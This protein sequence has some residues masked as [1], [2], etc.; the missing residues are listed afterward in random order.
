M[1]IDS[2]SVRRIV[3]LLTVTALG[4]AGGAVPAATPALAASATLQSE[5]SVRP[6][7]VSSSAYP[8]YP[9]S[10]NLDY[11]VGVTGTFQFLSYRTDTV[12]FAWRLGDDGPF[13]TAPAADRQGSASITPD[14]AGMQTLYVRDVTADGSRL[15][16][17][18]YAFNVDDGPRLVDPGEYGTELVVGESRT[19]RLKPGARDVVSYTYRLRDWRGTT[20]GTGT[21]AARP[22]GTADL[23]WTATH[24]EIDNLTVQS[25][26]ADGTVSATRY[27]SYSVDGATPTVSRIP[28]VGWVEP[29]SFTARTRMADPVEYVVTV[30]S[31][32]ASRQTLTPAADGSATFQLLPTVKGT[33]YIYVFARDAA[34]VQTDTAVIL[35]SVSNRPPV[36]STAFPANGIGRVWPGSFTFTAGMPGTTEFRYRLNGGP[37]T[38]LPAGPDGKATLAWT[39]PAV[40]GY[41]LLV[42][43]ATATGSTSSVTEHRFQIEHRPVYL[44]QVS[45]RSVTTGEVHML[46]LTGFD[47]QKQDVVEVTPAGGEPVRAQVH[48][49][50]GDRVRMLAFVDLAGAAIG[51]ATVT[52]TPHDELGYSVKMPVTLQIVAP[53][54]PKATKLPAITGTV[55]VGSVVKAGTGTWTPDATS[56]KYQWAANGTAIKGATG[57]SLTIPAALLGK[58]LTVTV[59]AIRPGHPNGKASSKATVAIAKGKAPKATKKP[60]ISGTAKV[61][62]T[63]KALVGT[64][65]PKADSYRYEWRLN[66]KVIKGATG[67]TLKLKSSMRDKKLTVTVIARRSGHLDGKATSK[68]VTVRR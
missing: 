24:Y 1:R 37:V 54:A 42:W 12:A 10:P 68:V 39:P 20:H 8:A 5:Q 26:S 28:G 33:H 52:L 36:T 38:P 31:D 30:N 66:G 48:Q 3:A 67:K 18:A 29:T 40:G 55:A 22:D 6:P 56:Y 58:K 32:E 61:G 2:R 14:R 27:V 13:G 62:R 15:T 46:E 45:P 35:W 57:A 34:G 19:V 50:T 63:V 16:E 4:G 41:E 60:T 47:L 64:W 43:S 49:V 7:A 51:P 65:S 59:T 23:T 9:N 53:P 25:V 44:D 11:T 17:T 21:V